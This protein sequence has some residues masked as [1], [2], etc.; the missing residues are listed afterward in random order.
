MLRNDT[1]PPPPLTRATLRGLLY[2]LVFVV[3]TALNCFGYLWLL[4]ASAARF[5]KHLRHYLG[6]LAWLE[7]HV[8][9]LDYRMIGVLPQSGPALIAMKHHPPG[10]R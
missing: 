2:T 4:P 7:R 1:A 6:S 10:K 8:L 5:R 9:G 3:W